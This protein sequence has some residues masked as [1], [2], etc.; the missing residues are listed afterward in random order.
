MNPYKDRANPHW[1]T[2]EVVRREIARAERQLLTLYCEAN[3][4]LCD[5]QRPACEVLRLKLK[6]LHETLRELEPWHI[7]REP[8]PHRDRIVPMPPLRRV[9]WPIRALQAV[10][11]ALACLLIVMK[12]T[13][14]LSL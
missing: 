4:T 3:P 5:D 13:G 14:T 6:S 8:L 1:P 2:A 11:A 7:E 10:V 9:S 12:C